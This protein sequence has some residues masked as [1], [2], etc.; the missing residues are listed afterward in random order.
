M[1]WPRFSPLPHHGRLLAGLA[2]AAA[3]SV[4]GCAPRPDDA[5]AK[6]ASRLIAGAAPGSDAVGH[7]VLDIDESELRDLESA[8]GAPDRALLADPVVAAAAFGSALGLPAATEYELVER[9]ESPEEGPGAFVATVRA[10]NP[11]GAL[12]LRLISQPGAD[13]RPTFWLINDVEHPPPGGAH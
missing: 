9:S 5:A 4:A 1:R 6:V 3:L 10:G 13:G 12:L 7:F 11:G 8:A 2:I